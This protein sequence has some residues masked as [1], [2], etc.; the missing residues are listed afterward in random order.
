M[1][2]FSTETIGITLGVITLTFQ[3]VSPRNIFE[4]IAKPFKLVLAK[5]GQPSKDITALT[6][7]VKQLELEA[8]ELHTRNA[9]LGAEIEQTVQYG[10]TSSL[11]RKRQKFYNRHS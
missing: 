6:E 11:A 7:R 1:E 10:F 2:V 8:G 5:I 3:L 9:E 4:A